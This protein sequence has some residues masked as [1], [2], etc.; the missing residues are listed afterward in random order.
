[1][2]FRKTEKNTEQ[3]CL[4]K[5][6]LYLTENYLFSSR[7]SVILFAFDAGEI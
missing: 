3:K 5:K 6:T 4:Y 7:L 1:M 2:K